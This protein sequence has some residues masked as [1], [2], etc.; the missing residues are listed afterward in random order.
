MTPDVAAAYDRRTSPAAVPAM[1]RKGRLNA[2]R[3]LDSALGRLDNPSRQPEVLRPFSPGE[4]LLSR[5]R[6]AKLAGHWWGELEVI[7]IV[8]K[9]AVIRGR[10]SWSTKVTTTQVTIEDLRGWARA[11]QP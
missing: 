9:Y 1:I 7:S 3:A 10:K 6:T 11:N 5:G 4:R 8:G 2:K